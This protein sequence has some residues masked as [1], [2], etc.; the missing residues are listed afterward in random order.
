MA[1]AITTP[2]NSALTVGSYL[3]HALAEQ[4]GSIEIAGVDDPLANFLNC[5]GTLPI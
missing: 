2:A 4:F 1:T 3:G 5:Q